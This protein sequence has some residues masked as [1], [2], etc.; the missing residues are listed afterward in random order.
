MISVRT[1]C[2]LSSAHLN[3]FISLERFFGV[4]HLNPALHCERSISRTSVSG[5]ESITLI[6][7]D[8]ELAE[9]ETKFIHHYSGMEIAHN[10][11]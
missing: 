6:S 4:K 8:F 5:R 11:L 9:N 3:V 1:K 10:L 7:L 2:F